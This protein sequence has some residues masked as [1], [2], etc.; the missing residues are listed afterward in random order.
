MLTRKKFKQRL[1][2]IISPD[3]IRVVVD[4]ENPQQFYLVVY[5]GMGTTISAAIKN[6]HENIKTCVVALLST[7]ELVIEDELSMLFDRKI[8][9]NFFKFLPSN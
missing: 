3:F 5:G 8:A 7:G 2:K 4:R 6:F 9:V 1:R